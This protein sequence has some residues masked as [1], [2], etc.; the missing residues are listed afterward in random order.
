MTSSHDREKERAMDLAEDSRET[1]WAYPSF[2]EELFRGNFRWELLHPFPEQSPEDKR[3]GDEYISKIRRVLEAYID[4]CEVDRS[5]EIPEEAILA[6]AEDP[7]R[8]GRQSRLA[9]EA[10]QHLSGAVMADRY[11]A[12]ITSLIAGTPR[13][14]PSVESLGTGEAS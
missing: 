12:L 8:R 10:Q 9:F 2:I 11:R 7:E 5:G 14:N 3:A 4:P 13:Q 1:E 6:L